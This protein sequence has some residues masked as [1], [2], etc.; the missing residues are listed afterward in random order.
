VAKTLLVAD[1]QPAN[2]ELFRMVVQEID[3]GILV[4]T[5]RDGAEALAQAQ[6]SHPDLM[7]MD[8]K[9]PGLDGWEATRRLKSDPAT[10]AIPIVAVTA[11]A[12]PGDRDRAFRAGCD[13]YLTKPLDIPALIAM[14]RERLS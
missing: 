14:L 5:A 7:L 12:M 11:Q 9:M 3:L 2:L 10:A 1:D 8:L 13:G 6:R 4:L